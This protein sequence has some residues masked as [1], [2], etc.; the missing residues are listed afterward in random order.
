MLWL[1]ELIPPRF[2][3]PSFSPL[4]F[5]PYAVPSGPHF[6]VGLAVVRGCYTLTW[7]PLWVFPPLALVD[8]VTRK[9]R[10]QTL[11]LSPFSICVTLTLDR[12][13]PQSTAWRVVRLRRARRRAG[14]D[15]CARRPTGL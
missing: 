1:S 9:S 13:L 6:N 14:I 11:P 15:R 10:M 12:Q 2:P 5:L 7:L 3:P 4:C 8:G